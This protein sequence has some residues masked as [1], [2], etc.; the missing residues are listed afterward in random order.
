MALAG[1]SSGG[2]QSRRRQQGQ[3]PQPVPFSLLGLLWRWVGS[4]RGGELLPGF[5]APRPQPG[6]AAVVAQ[7]GHYISAQ[8]GGDAFEL[9]RLFID[10]LEQSSRTF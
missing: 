6:S 1:S 2:A 7:D 10:K 3:Q 8:C 4:G 9:S 5:R